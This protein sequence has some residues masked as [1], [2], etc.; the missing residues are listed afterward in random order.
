MKGTQTIYESFDKSFPDK[1]LSSRY[2]SLYQDAIDFVNNQPQHF[3]NFDHFLFIKG[4]VNPL[5]ALNQQAINEYKIYS[6]SFVD[7]SLNRTTKSIFDKGLYNGLNPKG[8]YLRVDDEK[9]LGE[10]DKVGKLLF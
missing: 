8:I 1:A 3:S 2:L 4:F 6:R 9:A 5:F 7:Y 10:I